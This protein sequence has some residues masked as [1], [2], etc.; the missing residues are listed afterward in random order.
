MIKC[1]NTKNNVIGK[2]I[3]NIM[4]NITKIYLKK[5]KKW[6][7]NIQKIDITNLKKHILILLKIVCE[8][9]ELCFLNT[10]CENYDLCIVYI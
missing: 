5:R 7:E 9:Y 8:D 10:V 6:E 4:I 3:K 2:I 1:A